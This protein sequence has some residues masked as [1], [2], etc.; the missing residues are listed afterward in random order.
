MDIRVCCQAAGCG[1]DRL[2]EV[3]KTTA[4]GTKLITCK[5]CGKDSV[6]FAARAPLVCPVCRGIGEHVDGCRADTPWGV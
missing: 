6:I 5:V 2:I 1:E 3:V 4:A